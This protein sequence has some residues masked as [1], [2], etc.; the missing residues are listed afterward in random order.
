MDINV[1]FNRCMFLLSCD[2]SL[3]D[4]GLLREIFFAVFCWSRLVAISFFIE[5]QRLSRQNV[6]VY[7]F[8]LP[9]MLY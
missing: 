8:P 2:L 9:E 3:F 6:T 5:I 7:V 1:S 4:V